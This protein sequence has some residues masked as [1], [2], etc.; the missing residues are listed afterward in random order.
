MMDE[1]RVKVKVKASPSQ[2]MGVTYA[3]DKKDI[4]DFLISEISNNRYPENLWS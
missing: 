2:W 3:D 4:K 1:E